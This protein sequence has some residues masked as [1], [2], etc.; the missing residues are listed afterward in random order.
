LVNE[1][2]V[3]VLLSLGSN[4]DPAEHLMRAIKLL[5]ERTDLVGVSHVFRTTPIGAPSSPRFLNAAAKIRFVGSPQALK[6]DL[7]RPIENELGRV[8]I[9]DLNAPRTIDIDISIFGCLVVNDQERD[10]V[11]PAPEI[12]TLAHVALPLAD[13]APGSIHPETGETLEELAARFRGTDGIERVA[14]PVLSIGG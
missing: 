6:F 2:A 8:R 10:I 9:P 3:P 12:L 11:L 1:Q 4:L 13:L 14:T 7:L 5:A